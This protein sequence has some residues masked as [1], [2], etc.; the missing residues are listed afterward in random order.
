MKKITL[1]LASSA[2]LKPEREQFE[3]EIYPNA[4]PGLTGIFFFTWIFGKIFPNAWRLRVHKANTTKRF[5]RQTFLF[6]WLTPKSACIPA[7]NLKR[8]LG[9]SNPRRSRLF[10]PI[11]KRPTAS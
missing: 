4:R 6:Y 10:L 2:E 11:S 3:I 1:F 8:L 7:K 9:G 5:R